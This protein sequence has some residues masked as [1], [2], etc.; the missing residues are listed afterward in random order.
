M[1]DLWAPGMHFDPPLNDAV[2]YYHQLSLVLT[3][4]LPR[5]YCLPVQAIQVLFEHLWLLY[6]PLGLLLECRFH[7]QAS[8]ES[9][10]N[11]VTTNHTLTIKPTSHSHPITPRTNTQCLPCS[12]YPIALSPNHAVHIFRSSLFIQKIGLLH[13]WHCCC[14]IS[15][16]YLVKDRDCAVAACYFLQYFALGLGISRFLRCARVR[17]IGRT[18]RSYVD[19]R[20]HKLGGSSPSYVERYVLL[21]RCCANGIFQLSLGKKRSTLC[22]YLLAR[23]PSNDVPRALISAISQANSPR[24]DPTSSCLLRLILR[25]FSPFSPPSTP[26]AT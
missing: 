15:C 3:G 23:V 10:H 5:Q 16:V 1:S 7:G 25:F 19:A 14:R 11:H 8:L 6:L 21:A 9:L 17:E 2:L 13:N 4:N 18:R 12:P 26:V 22:T 20:T 24:S